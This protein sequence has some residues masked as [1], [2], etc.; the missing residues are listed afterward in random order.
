MITRIFTIFILLLITSSIPLS[1]ADLEKNQ[2]QI[3]IIECP[4]RES[5]FSP[6]QTT[7]TIGD[8]VIWIN[9]DVK[10]HMISSGSGQS[11][12]DGWFS[13]T[14]IPS[15]GIFS[16][17]F[18]RKGVFVY[19]DNMHPYMQ[20]VIIVDSSLQSSFIKMQQSYFSDWCS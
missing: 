19:F 11:G 6:C 20:G 14:I 5:C 10:D 3:D 1:Y 18:D 15:H 8:T 12:P 7:I 4:I 17:T 2:R 9:K 13:S 16:H